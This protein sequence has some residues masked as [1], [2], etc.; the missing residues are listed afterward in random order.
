MKR[1]GW[2]GILM[3]GSGILMVWAGFQGVSLLAT[4]K[5]VLTGSPMPTKDDP[6]AAATLVPGVNTAAEN[7]ATQ[8]DGEK[9]DGWTPIGDGTAGG[10]S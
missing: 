9:V 5:S 6:A 1:A 10:S 8:L 2:L 3:I 7:I 4:F